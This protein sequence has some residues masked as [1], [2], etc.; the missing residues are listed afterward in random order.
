[1]TSRFL[2]QCTV[3]LRG[4]GSPSLAWRYIGPSLSKA[5]ARCSIATNRRLTDTVPHMGIDA[6]EPTVSVTVH[7][8]GR[9]I[10]CGLRPRR[11]AC[12]CA[13]R[14]RRRPRP[15]DSRQQGLLQVTLP[16]H[17]TAGT[18]GYAAH[19]PTSHRVGRVPDPATI[20]WVSPR[21]KRGFWNSEEGFWPPCVLV[22]SPWYSPPPP[23][24]YTL[25]RVS[26]QSL[27]KGHNGGGKLATY[28]TKIFTP[29]AGPVRRFVCNFHS[30]FTDFAVRKTG[31]GMSKRNTIK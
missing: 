6:V 21:G 14:C 11:S 17:A 16:T 19:P 25:K 29:T 7:L 1:M 2:Q 9:G 30:L 8:P 27:N 23:A 15:L 31:L 28:C 3:L 18:R 12:F 10:S 4:H 20:P 5:S 24:G 13:S 22:V 26:G